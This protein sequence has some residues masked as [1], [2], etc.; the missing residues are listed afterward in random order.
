MATI[1]SPVAP[2][3]G[4]AAFVVRFA[5][6]FAVALALAGIL[7]AHAE[8]AASIVAIWWRS[9]TFAHGFIVL[10]ICAWL[11]WERRDA[12]QRTPAIPWY[13]ALGIVAIA[14]A[15]WLVMSIAQVVGVRQFALAFMLQAAIVAVVGLRVA[16]IA[17]FPL[18]F[19]LF[20]VPFG[21]FMIP[22]LIEWTADFTVAALRFSGVPVYREAN[23]F[24]IPSGAWSVVEACSG[25]RYL[26]ASVMVG[27][28]YAAITYRTPWRR[29]A[30]VAASVLVPI[31]ANWVRAYM[32]VMLGHLSNN[33]LAAGVDHLIYGWVFFG[34]VMALLF[35]VGSWWAEP[36]D[37]K[38]RAAATIATDSPRQVPGTRLFA[39]A[40]AAIIAAAVWRSMIANVDGSM[41]SG[42]VELA[43]VEPTAGFMRDAPPST[44]KPA[45]SGHSATLREGFAKG[46]SRVGLY[47]AYYR[48]QS[49][50]R[51][52]VTSGNQLVPPQEDAWIEVERSSVPIV[53]AGTTVNALRVGIAG[54]R[55]RLVAY[56]VFWVDGRATGSEYV[57]KAWLA[58]SR[59]SGRPGDAALIV[60]FAR[61]ES[62]DVAREALD[63]L[64]GGIARVLEAADQ[65]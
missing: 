19:M 9:E 37:A 31:V 40:I 35:W 38:A 42:Q 64:S 61:E 1:P 62:G 27:V 50:G 8:T 32:I 24:I 2:T 5:P 12:L 58:W 11:A 53:F 55:E 7:I 63:A 49:K 3:S 26:I 65:R 41:E 39:V 22:T 25:L 34:V 43:A 10:P 21:E 56:R 14:G 60:T 30:F 29:T 47:V 23:H 28:V 51:E 59:L 54:A 16:R 52:L 45:Y 18:L 17:A 36:R 46:D 15:L 4:I 6:L 44:W 20:A 13:P 57:A 33:K 48:N